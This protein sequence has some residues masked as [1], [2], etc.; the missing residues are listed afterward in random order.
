M[1]ARLAQRRPMFGP[2]AAHVW[3]SGGPFGPAVAHLAHP[4][5]QAPTAELP[6]NWTLRLLSHRVLFLNWYTHM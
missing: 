1:V 5:L 3:P 4:R 6:G 2:A